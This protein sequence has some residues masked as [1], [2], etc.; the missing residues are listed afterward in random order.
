VKMSPLPTSDTHDSLNTS[1]KT[2]K[3][4]TESARDALYRLKAT[5]SIV[6]ST[7]TPLP[8]RPIGLATLSV[9]NATIHMVMLFPFLPQMIRHF[10]KSEEEIAWL[11]GLVSSAYFLGGF[12]GSYVWGVLADYWGRRPVILCCVFASA[13]SALFFGFSENILWAIIARIAAGCSNGIIGTAK[14]IIGDVTDDSNQAPGMVF[15][16]VGWSLSSMIAPFIGGI[17]SEPITKYPSLENTLSYYIVE[18]LKS[19]PFLLPNLVGITVN[20]IFFIVF[21]F[22]LEETKRIISWTFLQR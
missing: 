3:T 10:G 5:L 16:G 13:V 6:P 20:V 2:S 19:Y 17:L 11:A 4:F 7:A 14:A 1:A 21:F 18:L 15:F 12:F 9:F 22:Y 8:W